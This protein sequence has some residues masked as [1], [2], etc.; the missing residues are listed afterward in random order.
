M[1]KSSARH[2]PERRV[3][4]FHD[5]EEH[6]N[7]IRTSKYRWWSF[8]PLNLWE[9]FQN[10][11]NVYFL[12]IAGM[13]CVPAITITSGKPLILAPL[14]FV[15]LVA[16]AKDL[17]EDVKRKLADK[18]ENERAVT[19]V[20]SGGSGLAAMTWRD[21]RPGQ[22]L[23]LLKN[24]AVPADSVVL[25]SSDANGGCSVETMNLDGETN[26][27]K[28]VSLVSDF[29]RTKP[30][31]S[32][33]SQRTGWQDENEQFHEDLHHLLLE[34]DTTLIFEE[35]TAALYDFKGYMMTG[36]QKIGASVNNLLLR[37]SSIQQT[38]WVICLVTYC[39]HDTRIMRNS[40]S[41]RYKP[42]L[43]DIEMNRLIKIIFCMQVLICAIGGCAYLSWET[44]NFKNLWYERTTEDLGDNHFAYTFFTK[45]GTWAL[46]MANMVPI[47]LLVTLTTVKFIQCKFIQWDKNLYDHLRNKEAAAQ[48]SQVLESLGQVTHVFS[49]KTG[50]LTCNEMLY[51]C[52]SLHKV[53]GSSA[54]QNTGQPMTDPSVDFDSTAFLNDIASGDANAV[55]MANFLLCHAVCHTVT[56]ETGKE[57][58][59]GKPK[60]AA[61]SPDELALVSMA[62]EVGLSFVQA[63]A[64]EVMLRVERVELEKA[65]SQAC[66]YQAGTQVLKIELLDLCEFD[67]DRKRMSVV[68]RYP[69]GKIVCLLKGADSSVLK[70]VGDQERTRMDG[71]LHK[72]AEGGLRTLCLAMRVL[73]VGDFQA[74]HGEYKA[75]G[76]SVDADKD[77]VIARLACKL[78]EVDGLQLLGSTAIEDK[79]QDEVP[80][81]IFMLRQ[82]GICVWVLTGDKVETA[83]NIGKSCKLLNSDMENIVIQEPS[84]LDETLKKHSKYKGRTDLRAI[85]VTG[86]VLADILEDE[87]KC[88]KFYRVAMTCRSVLACR[89]S[90]KQKADVVELCKRL[91]KKVSVDGEVPVTLAIGD[92][93]NDVAMINAAHVGVGLS[94]KEGA[95][96]ARAADFAFC[97]FRFLKR[98]MFVHGR[99]SYRRNAVVVNYN[100]YKNLLVVLPPFFYGPWMSYSGQPF[101]AQAMYQLYNVTFTFLPVIFYAVFDRPFDAHSM[102][103]L[104][105]NE[106]EYIPG[107]E[108]RLFNPKVFVL[109]VAAAALQ[110]ALITFIAF[111]AFDGNVGTADKHALDHLWSTGSVIFAWVILGANLT[112]ARRCVSVFWFTSVCLIGCTLF[113]IVLSYIFVCRADKCVGNGGAGY[114]AG[115]QILYGSANTR[116]LVATVLFSAGHLLVGEPLLTYAGRLYG[117]GCFEAAPLRYEGHARGYR[118][119]ELLDMRAD[120]T[121]DSRENTAGPSSRESEA[122]LSRAG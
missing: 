77:Q 70:F 15:L 117:C 36:E 63:T 47:S 95:Q 118:Q 21:V 53:Y 52:C 76:E 89:V 28:K 39:G 30:D 67:N 64:R 37:G 84:I 120:G 25:D 24:D 54:G 110:A 12:V 60:Y 23:K 83:I 107:R 82:A 33:V 13:Q 109:W 17:L 99:E 71:D 26:L 55:K 80:D 57:T 87:A 98:L 19:Q 72:F 4:P 105:H 32:G 22:V 3:N 2:E 66:G 69:N 11:A 102:T 51:K 114:G 81:T 112:L 44:A 56:V 78:E 101:Y 62:R 75:A 41:S 29:V 49:D 97:Q 6:T 116:F 7:A 31:A 50:T 90:P 9:Q 35:P 5:E 68:V 113:H 10:L 93:A 122:L 100:F 34:Q 88:E 43:L 40:A 65:L 58:P 119:D 42:S 73:S 94:G 86:A 27:K 38:E 104:E 115:F 103:R 121:Q 96:A 79:L 20:K 108:K 91:H 106:L 14:C 18:G 59:A 16:A 61:S 92:G 46:Q 74:W 8:I 85:T 1:R 48:T 45:M 111:N